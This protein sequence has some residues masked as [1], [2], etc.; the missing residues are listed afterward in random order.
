MSDKKRE[1]HI[2]TGNIFEDLG[3]ENSE[4][5]LM[6]SKLLSEVSDLIEATKLSQKEIGKILGISQPKVSMLVS[7][8]LSAFSTEILLHYLSL[9]GCNIEIL[10]KKPRTRLSAK[11]RGRIAVRQLSPVRIRRRS[12]KRVQK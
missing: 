12:K 11:H 1:F 5:L 6:R 10:L 2:T 8:K 7:E 3:L 4:E 9:L